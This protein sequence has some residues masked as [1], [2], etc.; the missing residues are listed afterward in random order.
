M[1]TWVDQC[2]LYHKNS[3]SVI[4]TFSLENNIVTAPGPTLVP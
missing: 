4:K 2:C 1:C 3:F